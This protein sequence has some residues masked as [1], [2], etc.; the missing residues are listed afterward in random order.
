MERLQSFRKGNSV[1][2]K[3]N[4]LFR[5][6]LS[7]FKMEGNS[8]GFTCFSPRASQGSIPGQNSSS[9]RTCQFSRSLGVGTGYQSDK[10]RTSWEPTNHLQNFPDLVQNFHSSYPHKPCQP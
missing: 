2:S 3:L 7:S 9:S 5:K 4:Q 1:H 8:T 6:M 10:D